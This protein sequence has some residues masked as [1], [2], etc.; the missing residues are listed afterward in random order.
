MSLR[1]RSMF[2]DRERVP[3]V[4]HLHALTLR[5]KVLGNNDIEMNISDELHRSALNWHV[6][7]SFSHTILL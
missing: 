2:L 4:I 6:H 5:T 3:I 1:Y 7:A